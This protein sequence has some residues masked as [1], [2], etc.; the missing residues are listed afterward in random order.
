[1]IFFL[2]FCLKNRHSN[3]QLPLKKVFIKPSGLEYFNP[4][5]DE[6][7]SK[8]NRIPYHNR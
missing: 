1:M 6:S 8:A 2:H 5:K 7:L 3:N 4:F